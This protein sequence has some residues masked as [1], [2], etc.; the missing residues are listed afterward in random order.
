MYSTCS[1]IHVT[2]ALRYLDQNTVAIIPDLRSNYVL[3]KSPGIDEPGGL[4]WH[5]LVAVTVAWFVVFLCL[6]KGIRSLG[7]VRQRSILG[8]EITNT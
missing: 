8:Y 7:K 4:V 6:S 1:N 3:E 5:L 2:L